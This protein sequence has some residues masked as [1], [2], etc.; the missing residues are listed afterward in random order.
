MVNEKIEEAINRQVNAELASA[1]LYLSMSAHFA[2]E[3]L[4]GFAH[5]MRVQ[6]REEA[7]HAM[8]FFDHLVDRGGRASLAAIDQPPGDFGSAL[9]VFERVL[10]HEREVTR[11][12]HALYDLSVGE[13]DHASL[14][15]LLSFISEQVEEE[16][17]AADIV[18]QLRMVGEQKGPLL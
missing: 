15:M 1:Y 8:R 2:S 5:W 13:R 4:P 16:K 7:E 18:D 11:A 17:T 3:G 9:S 12:I 6:A 14:P 10:D